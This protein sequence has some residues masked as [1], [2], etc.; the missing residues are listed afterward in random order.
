MKEEKHEIGRKGREAR[1]EGDV[2]KEGEGRCLWGGGGGHEEITLLL[3]R[4]KGRSREVA[5]P[6]S[7]VPKKKFWCWYERGVGGPS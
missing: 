7:N 4:A 1:A 2:G 6:Q 5:N 3:W